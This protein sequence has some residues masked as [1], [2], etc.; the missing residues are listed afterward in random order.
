MGIHFG[1]DLGPHGT[2]FAAEREPLQ[3]DNKQSLQRWVSLS[4]ALRIAP[5]HSPAV[6]FKE[7]PQS[8]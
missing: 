3:R 2:T 8:A 6:G 7:L 1:I 4:M 5:I